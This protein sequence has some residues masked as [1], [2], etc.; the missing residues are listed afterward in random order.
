MVGLM[1]DGTEI[2]EAFVLI[3]VDGLMVVCCVTGMLRGIWTHFAW[4]VG[5][6]ATT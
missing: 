6:P 3:L 2:A 4:F 1:V 5:R